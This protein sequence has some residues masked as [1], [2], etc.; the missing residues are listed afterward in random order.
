MAENPV[1]HEEIVVRYDP[2]TF[3]IEKKKQFK[4][5]L[6]SRRCSRHSLLTH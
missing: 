1:I 5:K 2:A 4:G 6:E 3:A